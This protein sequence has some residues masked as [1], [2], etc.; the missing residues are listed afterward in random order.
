[1]VDNI[2]MADGKEGVDSFVGKRKPTW[3]HSDD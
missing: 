1:M 2:N 3:T